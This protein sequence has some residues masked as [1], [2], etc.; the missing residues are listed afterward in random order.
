MLSSLRHG[1]LA[2]RARRGESVLRTPA[3][4]ALLVSLGAAGLLVGV[5][6][7]ANGQLLLMIFAVLSF[8]GS[9]GLLSGQ[10]Q[11]LPWV[12]PAIIGTLAISRLKRRYGDRKAAALRRAGSPA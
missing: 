8:S 3:H 6:G 1:T 9:A 12:A 5:V 4:R 10:W 7:V 11:I 2:L